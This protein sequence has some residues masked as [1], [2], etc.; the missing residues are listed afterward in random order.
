LTR[1][2][3][4][5]RGLWG[6]S[7]WVVAAA[8]ALSAPGMAAAQGVDR[9]QPMAEAD[10]ADD[11]A[12]VEEI[13]VT[14]SL[15]RG[16]P[17]NAALPVDV[18]GQDELERQ[19]S[20]SIVDLIKSLPVSN[21]VL[22]DTNQF[23]TR[24][25][26]SEGSGSVNLRGLGPE[27]TLVLLNGRRIPI[28]P[29]GLGG[30]GVVD[31]NMIPTAAIGRI[32]VLKDGAAATYGSDAIAGVVNFITRENFSGVELG[33]DYQFIE[34]S[35]GNYS[36]SFLAGHSWENVD[37][38]FSAGHQHRSK[39]EATERDFALRPY[40]E[41]PEGGF[42][43]GSNPA[44]FVTPAGLVRD[45][46]CGAL[47]NYP[48]FAGAPGPTT[49]RCYG[50]FTPFDNLIELEDRYQL[51]GSMNVELSENHN[52]HIDANY[53]YT[54]VPEWNTSPSYLPLGSPSN[55][56]VANAAGVPI[57]NG[58][59]V[60]GPLNGAYFVPS[61]NPGLLA[62]IAANPTLTT[63]AGPGGTALALPSATLLGGG[64]SLAVGT[65]RPF[66]VGGNPLFDNG[67]SR[68]VREYD[69]FRISA[70]FDGDLT[71][72]G[73]TGINYDVSVTYG[74]QT[75]YRSGYDS[76]TNRLA[77]ALRGFGGPGCDRQPQVPGVQVGP[78]NTTVTATNQAEFAGKNGCQFFNPFSNAVQQNVITGQTNPQF[79]A[80][81]TNSREL[82][83]WFFVE[84]FTEQTA[85]MFVTD[86][87]L[88]GETGIE[89]GGGPIQFAFGGQYRKDFFES[90][91]SDINN[92][93][94]NPCVGSPDF[95]VTSCTG[96]ARNGPL[97][98]LGVG[99]DAEL[100]RD[101]Y[102]LFGE[103]QVPV[104]DTFNIQ[105]AARYE[106]YG[107]ATGSTF[108]PK[109]SARWEILPQVALRG[110]AGTTFR[111]P[112]LRYLDP[113]N[114]TA[115]SFIA[116]SFRAFDIAGNPNLSPE[117]AETYSAGVVLDLGGFKGSIDYY[118]FKFIDALIAEPI[119][120]IANTF[121]PAGGANLC[122]AANAAGLQSRF[123]FNDVTGDGIADCSA[124]AIGRIQT[125]YVNGPATDTSGIDFLGEYD[126]GDV[127]GGE[128]S[129]GATVTYVL[130][131]TVAPLA[132]EGITVQPGFEA[133]G[134]LNYQTTAYP[135]P[136]I[137]G[138]GY[139]EYTR[140]IHNL[141]VTL[142]YIDGYTDQRTAPFTT[143]YRDTAGNPVTNP[144][145][146]EIDR[147]VT[148]DATY[149]LLLPGDVT[150]TATV[151]N[152]F[153]EDPPFA[154]LDLNYDPFT[155]DALGRTYKIGLRKKF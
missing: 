117:S 7:P 120:G 108:D 72:V 147:F 60:Y 98:F 46:Q 100:E 143:V 152:V 77:L 105:L 6:A 37:I 27:R 47:G 76:L 148:V 2:N 19:G 124:A 17:E 114:V 70:G 54:E 141:R 74:Q 4:L 106:D 116:G 5:N 90:D 28:N 63:N 133:V 95:F 146:K 25:Q 94:V 115:L 39:L 139:A 14:G 38:L 119:G 33:A 154:R 18:I 22:G 86:A 1:S 109:I 30:A 57:E 49:Q 65:W 62:Y 102:A 59:A 104:T 137:K 75:G 44:V 71:N 32:E 128:F 40:L 8:I 36:V 97:V 81:L 48:G 153:D 135:I 92:S 136:E 126:F 125:R 42:S 9:P 121:F 84:G 129:I 58:N 150:F 67:P 91:Y 69:Q 78:G 51:F 73:L 45:S 53:G 55:S 16:T 107:G 130:D 43:G 140:D 96:A 80:G 23:D 145:G 101:V 123:T 34:G 61:Y 89:L 85:R 24:A 35:D 12:E 144:N 26:G 11:A 131:Y 111:G 41:N 20:P 82:T 50:Q 151:D 138:T 64:T 87:V 10:Q 112:P 83:E 66:K 113:S 149:R 79:N 132:V 103:L 93:K 29:F 68:G 88:S 110:S 13:V 3:V 99:A 142:N 21:G 31:T 56:T 122:G 127:F 155:A 15:I 134:F 52:F 118:K